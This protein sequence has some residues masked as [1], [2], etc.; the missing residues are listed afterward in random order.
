MKDGTKPITCCWNVEYG[1]PLRDSV[2]EQNKLSR[3]KFI[4]KSK[5]QQRRV[6]EKMA[7]NEESSSEDEFEKKPVATSLIKIKANMRE[8]TSKKGGFASGKRARSERH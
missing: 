3:D 1:I 8:A 7:E 6:R 4:W 5:L 2:W